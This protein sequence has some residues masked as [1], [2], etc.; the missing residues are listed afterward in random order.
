MSIKKF[1]T[2]ELVEELSKREGV[3]TIIAEP[4]ENKELKM[5]GPAIIIKVID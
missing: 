1:S 2:K 3:E 5:N 4:Y